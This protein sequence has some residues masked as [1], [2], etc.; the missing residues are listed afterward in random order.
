MQELDG[1]NDISFSQIKKSTG[2][3]VDEENDQDVFAGLPGDSDD[4]VSSLVAQKP[5]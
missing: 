3:L 4:D 5:Q 2:F 1:D